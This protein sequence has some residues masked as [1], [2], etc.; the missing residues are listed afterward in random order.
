VG[1]NRAQD[2]AE[3][4]SGKPAILIVAADAATST[5]H[6]FRIADALYRWSGPYHYV[7]V[8]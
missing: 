8:E 4:V 5:P 7:D 6:R 1:A 3:D 2:A